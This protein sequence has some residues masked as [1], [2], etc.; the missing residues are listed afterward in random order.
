VGPLSDR[1]PSTCRDS[2]QQPERP[3]VTEPVLKLRPEARL[4]KGQQ[5]ELAP[6]VGPVVAAAER[7]YAVGVVA[8]AQRAR[9]QVGR[10]DRALPADDAALAGDLGALLLRRLAER[11]RRSG[12]RRISRAESA[13]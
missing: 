13:S 12:V 8:A 1:R 4:E 9:H 7:H 2:S 6:V 10:V 3:E 11:D 5:V